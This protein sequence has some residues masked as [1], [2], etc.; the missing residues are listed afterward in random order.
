MKALCVVVAVAWQ[1]AFFAPKKQTLKSLV[2]VLKDFKKKKRW[3]KTEYPPYLLPPPPLPTSHP[4]P[5]RDH[6]TTETGCGSTLI[7]C[8]GG[9]RFVVRG[10]EKAN[11]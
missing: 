3:S 6:G 7:G 4:T 8:R 11:N 1:G 5:W 10:T 2:K 9:G